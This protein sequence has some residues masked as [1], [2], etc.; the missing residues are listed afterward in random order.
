MA[1]R[2]VSGRLKMDVSFN[3]RTDQYKVRVC[4]IYPIYKPKRCETVSVGLPGAGPRSTHGR[5]LAVDDPRAMRNAAH[6]A[7]S[8][9]RD[10]IQ[11]LA[12]TNRRGTGWLVRPVH[13]GRKR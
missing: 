1:K 6:A 5:R 8:F 7:I 2:F 3:D 12:E 10:D 4:S 13:R 11:E 9:S